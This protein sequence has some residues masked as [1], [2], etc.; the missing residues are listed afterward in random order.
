MTD[1]FNIQQGYIAQ[2]STVNPTVVQSPASWDLNAPG[3]EAVVELSHSQTTSLIQRDIAAVIFDAV[4]AKYKIFRLLFD[5][6]VEYTKGD[7]FTYMEKTFGR[8]ALKATTTTGAGATSDLVVATGTEAY[9]TINKIV[10]FPD[11]TKAIVYKIAANT[12]S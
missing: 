6:P 2:P 3:S 12:I 9:V 8:T 5:K 7:V 10:V 1:Q 4:P 11:N